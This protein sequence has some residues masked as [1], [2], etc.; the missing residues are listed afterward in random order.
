VPGET[1]LSQPP[2]EIRAEL[3]VLAK[4]LDTDVP[5]KRERKNV[6]VGTWNIRAFGDLNEAWRAP[7]GAKPP[8]DL[9]SLRC[10]AEIVSRFDVMAIQ[11]VKGNIKALRHLLKALGPSWSFILTDVVK[12]TAGNYERLAFVFD[13]D[14]ANLSGLACELVVP[15]KWARKIGADLI[16]EQFARTPYAV[17][18]LAGDQTFILVTLHVRYGKAPQR[19]GELKAIAHWLK[20]WARETND[21]HQNLMVLGD[22]NIDREDDPNGRAFRSTGLRPPAQLDGL[23][24]T[25]F[26]KPGAPDKAKYFDQIAWFAGDRK[27]DLTMPLLAAGR[28]D[29]MDVALPYLGDATA[30]EKNK[31]DKSFR[32]SDHFPLWAEFSTDVG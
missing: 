8:R 14:R 15:R 7:H 6:L 19:A 27:A 23:T 2:K 4:R 31:T 25:I 20:D 32:I 16:D 17:S 30:N 9:E 11:E 18:F 10:I 22:F 12:S 1:V 29:F 5:R 24:R 3:A 26:E 28:F 21:F 13:T